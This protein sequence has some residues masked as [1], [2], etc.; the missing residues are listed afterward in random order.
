MNYLFLGTIVGLKGL[1]GTLK[2]DANCEM[3]PKPLSNV[4]VGY[5]L[6]FSE[7]FTLLE[8]KTGPSKY[9]YLKLKDVSTIEIAKK[10]I[11]KGVFVSQNDVARDDEDS[12][13]EQALNYSVIDINTGNIIGEA[14]S[15]IP[16]PGNDLILVKTGKGEFYL[17]YVDE[18]VKKFDRSE[19]TIY[20]D[21]ID[22]FLE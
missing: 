22:G 21:L 15:I 18:I 17:P 5:S 20:V 6:R 4:K 2:L 11:E 9:C 1:D 13:Y 14:I 16:N 19:N 3:L 7:N 12:L 10:L 8:Y